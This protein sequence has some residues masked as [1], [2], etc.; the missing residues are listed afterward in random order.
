MS[1]GRGALGGHWRTHPRSRHSTFVVE[2]LPGSKPDSG[3]GTAGRQGRGRQA[4]G[5]VGGWAPAGRVQHL[6]SAAAHKGLAS[7]T[8]YDH[9]CGTTA[10]IKMHN[11]CASTA[12][13]ARQ[14]QPG[15][16]MRTLFTKHLPS[17]RA[18]PALQPSGSHSVALLEHLKQFGSE[19]GTQPP[20][21]AIV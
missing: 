1:P 16:P 3:L 13:R 4:R 15:Q 19:Q 20:F 9:K 11:E 21:T 5:W 14:E 6:T 12:R 8:T 2:C 17:S 7:P 10:V 18:Y